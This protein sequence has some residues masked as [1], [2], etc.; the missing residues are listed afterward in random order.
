MGLHISYKNRI[1]GRLRNEDTN[2]HKDVFIAEG[3]D[4]LEGLDSLKVLLGIEPHEEIYIQ[5]KGIMSY[6]QFRD[7]IL[8]NVS[9]IY[10][11][12][13]AWLLKNHSAR[14]LAEF[15]LDKRSK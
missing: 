2:T 8:K 7:T 13:E 14:T 15:G 3:H 5:E 9:G 12:T 1:L 4:S 6:Q 10:L 11:T